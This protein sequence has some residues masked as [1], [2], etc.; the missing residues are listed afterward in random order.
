MTTKTY[1]KITFPD[2]T[3]YIGCTIEYNIRRS[4]HLN[5]SSKHKHTNR[6][7]QAV[8][9]KYGSNDEWVFEVL[10]V[11]T[12]DSERHKQLEYN[13]IKETPNTLNLK[14]GR[15]CLVVGHKR[16]IK[17]RTYAREWARKNKERLNK[18]DRDKRANETPEQRKER[19]T[20]KQHQRDNRTPEEL[21]EFRRKNSIR[22]KIRR[23]GP[24]GEEI[25][26]KD[27]ERYKRIQDKEIPEH[28]EKRLSR[29]R[30]YDRR[31][32][33]E[34]KRGKDNK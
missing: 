33:D 19:L 11:E 26:R 9:D 18:L 24:K 5:L 25:R 3:C 31:K 8:Y 21:E 6:N 15:E 14:D 4:Y 13:L 34:K 7:I 27:R 12:G 28:R 20:K 29:Q 10:F 17:D 2:N 30:E 32:R 23:S 16:K 1:Y 22:Q